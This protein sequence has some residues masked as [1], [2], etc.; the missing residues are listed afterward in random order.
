[1]S[2]GANT[3][4]GPDNVYDRFLTMISES[5]YRERYHLLGWR[6]Y[7]EIAG[8]YQASDVGLNIDAMHYETIYGTRTRLVEM[9]AAGLPVISST[10]CELSD[11]IDRQ[12]S[13]LIFETGNWQGLSKQI[14]AL[15]QDQDLRR[16]M[17][18]TALNYA[19]NELSFATT[20]MPI[21]TWVQNP[22]L[23]PDKGASSF[24][25]KLKQLEYQ[26]RSVV[27]QAIW[28]VANYDK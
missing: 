14:L 12:G 4:N 10:G 2:V 1:V 19:S 16:K 18:Q 27:R 11:L 17:A 7:A 26:T 6:P 8:Y 23:A 21:R 3:Y 28:Q 15:A 13:G 25:T 5:L 22:K 24:Q 20:T 9:M